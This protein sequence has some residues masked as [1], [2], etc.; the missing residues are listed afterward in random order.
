MKRSPASQRTP[1]PIWLAVTLLFAACQ[2]QAASP[3]GFFP[4]SNAV[5]GWTKSAELRTFAPEQLSEYIDGDAEKYLK[6]GVK[7]VATTD[8]KYRGQTEV[9]VDVYTMSTAA[10]AKTIFDS[11]PAM[12]AETPALGDA[13]R[14]YSQSLIFRTGPYL[15]RMVAYQES[16]QLPRAM[17]DLG[18]A[19]E[20]KLIR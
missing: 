1:L 20:S 19:L 12:N 2:Q 11:E 6:A 8:Y 13:A 3:A 9:V 14:L 4:D 7:T 16:P 15:V 17:L 18:R 10:A 5:S